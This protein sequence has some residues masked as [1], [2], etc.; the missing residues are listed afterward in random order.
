MDD[1]TSGLVVLPTSSGKDLLS[2]SV[3]RAFS[4]TTVCF[5]PFKC[6]KEAAMEYGRRFGCTV[7][8]FTAEEGIDR[9]RSSDVV[10]AAYEQAGNLLLGLLQALATAGRL[11]M[12]V[13]NE[14]HVPVT[15]PISPPPPPSPLPHTI[16]LF[17]FFPSPLVPPS[18]LTTV[19]AR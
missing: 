4:G 19:T 18:L 16:P 8:V 11:C 12:V 3:A 2:F 15:P 9:V 10:V 7:S 17:P 13:I 5:H 6:L 1:N 14:G